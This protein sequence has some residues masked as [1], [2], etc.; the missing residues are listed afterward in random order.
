MTKTFYSLLGVPE[1][2]S[3]KLIKNAYNNKALEFH[4]DKCNGDSETFLK[5]QEAWSVLK[6]DEKRREYDLNLNKLQP[7]V[8][9]ELQLNE[10]T[11]E[12]EDGTQVYLYT[13]RC[14]GEYAVREEDLRF[15]DGELLIPCNNCSFHIVVRK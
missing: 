11:V 15:L 6:D 9:E 12:E 13:C 3:I 5:I 14:G 4:P 7:K 2:A 1:K 8:Y 10:L